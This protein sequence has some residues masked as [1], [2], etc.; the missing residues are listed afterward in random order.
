METIIEI[1]ERQAE[2]ADVNARYK[3]E[4]ADRFEKELDELRAGAAYQ[5]DLAVKYRALV[6]REKAR[7]GV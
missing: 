2:C 3:R 7:E 5:A 6:E 1:L 4:Q